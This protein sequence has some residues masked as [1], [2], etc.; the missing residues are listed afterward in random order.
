MG[1]RLVG[2]D[3]GTTHT[4]A[5][6]FE[7][8]V[9]RKVQIFEVPRLGAPGRIA[10]RETLASVLYAPLPGELPD[11]PSW[12]IGDYAHRRGR[13]IPGRSIV[14]AKSWLSYGAVDRNAPILPWGSEDA[15][16]KLSPVDASTKILEHVHVEWNREFPK[17]PLEEQS[18]V[19]T[20]PASFDPTA[21]QLTLEAAKRTGLAVRLLEEP[22]AAFYDYLD[23]VGEASLHELLERAER[24]SDARAAREG[25]AH[26]EHASDARALVL[27]CDVGGGTTDLTLLSIARSPSGAPTIDRVAVGRHLLLG[28][29]NMDL[30]L[31]HA[32]ERELSQDGERLPPREFAQLVLASQFAKERLLSDPTLEDCPVTL[33]AR[34]GALVGGTRTVRLTRDR[35]E[36]LIVDGFF[37]EAPLRPLATRTR[38][39]LLGFGLPYETEPAITRHVAAFLHRHLGEGAELH[40][41]LLNGG[42]FLSERL[43]SALIRAIPTLS[44]GRVTL[45]HQPHPE[46]AVARGAAIY[47]RTILGEGL[48]I[49]G[50]SALGYYV[51]VDDAALGRK[52][53]AVCV[54]PRG[55]REAE[56]HRATRAQLSL[57][58]GKPVR[59]ELYSTDVGAIH[60]PGERVVLDEN[61]ELT[62]PIV[63]HFEDESPREVPVVLEGE[64]TAVGTLELACVTNEGG[65]TEAERRFAL[66]FELR[67]EETDLGKRRHPSAPPKPE[68]TDKLDEIAQQLHRIFGKSKAPVDPREVK[69]LFRDLEKRLGPRQQ[70]D[71]GLCRKLF[72]RVGPKFQ[73]RRRSPDHERLY[74]M[75]AGFLLR[76]GFGDPLDRTR[77]RL[78]APLFSH[79]LAFPDET[80]TWQQFFIAYRRVVAGLDEAEQLEVFTA[81]LPHL[82]PS[83]GRGKKKGA[84]RPLAEPE[85]IECASWLERLP[86]T[87][88]TS[89]GEAILERT[90]TK[91]D[92]LLWAALARVG[93]R[94]PV[95]ASLHH[96]VPPKVVENWLDHLLR[97][98]WEDL[99]TAPLAAIQMGRITG[100]RARDI[101]EIL[102]DTLCRRLER[103]GTPEEVFRPLRELV[104]VE[105]RE[106]AERFGE[107][108][109]VGLR[110]LDA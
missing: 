21:R 91:R 105:E 97:E 93:A 24:A 110:W 54:V 68:S 29:D 28:G 3:L 73:G 39:G 34:G 108:L 23:R 76:P 58:L 44:T 16:A 19:L 82:S 65:A 15:S 92:P 83:T 109:P 46:L 32:L 95:Y 64:L 71:L 7:P 37:P 85:M 61:F 87:E 67:G 22:Q 52:L 47:A 50:G 31:A 89:L 100:D 45:L 18:I 6:Y 17:Y 66:A 72:D 104:P 20:V 1:R 96:V 40:G 36:A 84:F 75:L 10:R 49:G 74:F 101:G 38:T 90:W 69:D 62:C 8:D 12:I 99:R 4:V 53:T 60:T 81:L 27:V 102:R 25:D 2:I 79:G 86:I 5:A 59:F 55:S 48:Q 51:A 26:D 77:V 35:V 41:L 63:A 78:L 94:V 14:S 80:R 70:W 30:A 13:E 42:V 57:T 98:K 88:R 107:E 33:A 56:V 106:R 43:A 9:D 103:L 11:S